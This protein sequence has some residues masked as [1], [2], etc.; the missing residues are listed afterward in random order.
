VT[1]DVEK[2]AVLRT[3]SA[4]IADKELSDV[5][6]LLHEAG[7]PE[8]SY[9][10]WWGD[11]RWEPG[12]GDR[13]ALVLERI[14]DLTREDV[15]DLALAVSKLYDEEVSGAPTTPAEPL[16]LFASHLA[17]QKDL[18][19]AVSDELALWG[20]RLFVAHDAIEPDAEWQREIERAL[21]ACHAG[22]AF[23]HPDFIASRWC[24]QEVGWL[25]GRGVPCL[26][27]KFQGQDPYGPLG[28][29]QARTIGD[30][31]T[32]AHVAQAVMDWVATKPALAPYVNASL[33]VALKESG[34]FNKTDRIWARLYTAQGMQDA[35]VAGLLTAIRD[36]DQV[37]NASGGTEEETGPYKEL[38]MKLALRQPGFAANL[39]LA[40]E[41]A[42]IREL[43]DVLAAAGIDTTAGTED[44]P[45]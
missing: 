34:S 17:T 44:P 27:L 38:A 26:A 6:L 28:K 21:S 15:N 42:R 39:E 16:Y 43:D 20:I 13:T 3:L 33:V 11:D 41:V 22:V 14:R 45:F 32:A 18:V 24:D 40:Q 35:E 37:Y 1:I 12:A 5:N 19:G 10:S 9:N 8:I 7:V 30:A 25:L 2:I 4:S 31:M 23:L 36:N 29:K